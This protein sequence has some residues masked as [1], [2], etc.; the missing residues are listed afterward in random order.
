MNNSP[1]CVDSNL[2]LKL[3]LLEDDSHQARE[4][5]RW[6]NQAGSEIV[7]PS[8]FWYEITS[9]LRNRVHRGNFTEAEGR[10]VLTSILDLDVSAQSTPGLHQHAW[11]LATQL[12]LPNAYDA[13]YLALSQSLGCHSGPRTPGCTRR[14]DETCRG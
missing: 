10:E 12:G 3:V 6:W 7:A 9:V 5:W 1:V 14:W 4:L 8:L 2:A 13:H 11:E